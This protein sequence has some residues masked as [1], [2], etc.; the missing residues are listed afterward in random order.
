M[1]YATV[2]L[3]AT[4]LTA[5]PATCADKPNEKRAAPPLD[6][7]RNDSP[8]APAEK[9]P[10]SPA[11]ELKKKLTEHD[12]RA[13]IDK[14]VS[15]NPKPITG[16]EDPKEAPDYRLP[17]GFDR[18]KQ[19][20]VRKAVGDLEVLGPRAFPF[21]IDRWDDKRYCLTVSEGINGYCRN[22]TVGKTCEMIVFNQIQPFGKWQGINETGL[23][24]VW[25]PNYPVH[26]LSSKKDAKKWCEERKRKTLAEIQLEVLDW[27]IA[28]E[29]KDTKMYS[30][31]ERNRLQELRKKL[32]ASKEPFL[33]GNYEPIDIEQ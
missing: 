25:R 22:Q 12:I 3:L 26:F 32:V 8:A 17:P 18:E 11:N 30:A 16:D 13:L 31:E 29:G 9:R 19:E 33:R 15:P 24:Y 28:E 23:K 4:I 5:A 20:L 14:L 2:L 21:L 10:A 6:P 7:F 1:T 27:A